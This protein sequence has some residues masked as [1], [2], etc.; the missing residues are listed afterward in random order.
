MRAFLHNAIL[1]V[2]FGVGLTILAPPSVAQESKKEPS[3]SVSGRVTIGDKPVPHAIVLVTR[4]NQGIQRTPPFRATT[5]EDGV[6]RVT[7]VPAGSYT[8][9][10]F[11]PAYVVAPESSF[12]QPGKS[13]SLGEGEEVEDLNFSLARGCVVTG[14]VTDADG[15]PLIEQRVAVMQVDERGQRVPN[16]SFDPFMFATD[17]RGVYRVYGL[18]PGRYK[19]SVGDA[20]DSGMVRIGFGGGIYA[21]TFHP[22]VADESKAPAIEVRA[23]GEAAD[24]DIKM[25]NATR[26]FV[27]TGRIIDADSGKPLPNLQYGHGALMREQTNI[28]GFG[29]TNNRTNENGDFR[30]D[31]LSAGRFAAFVIATEQVDF[32]SEPTVFE[33]TDSDVRGL[34]IRVRHGSSIVGMAVIDGSN[35]SEVVSKLS[36]LELRAFLRSEQ[37]SPPNLAPIRISPD[38]SFRI[39]GLQPGK[40]RIVL[41]GYPPQKGFTLLRVEREGVEQRDGIDIGAG[42]SVAGV[43]VVIGYGTG[44]I[45]GQLKFQG[46][47]PTPEMRYRV[48]AKRLETSESLTTSTMVDTR[49][50]FSFEG[51]VPGDYEIALTTIALRP[52]S[53]GGPPP[54]PGR[55]SQGPL[56]KQNVTVTNGAEADVTLVVELG[57]Q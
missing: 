26:T 27:A 22:N 7:G 3:S 15:R 55:A 57:R 47:Q 42:E 20:P 37:L 41:G 25:A 43:R 6:Y 14:R 34:E 56:A 29:F 54:P 23:G 28:G 11:T 19:I 45:R 32:Y 48:L 50:R 8:V 9:L 2:C 16:S 36:K 1:S 53:P 12:A 5:D 35:D 10:P 30:I 18:A 51:L 38:G 33:V 31:G 52:S 44:V 46:G 49:G 39:T 21:R 17:D 13:V 40:V 4:S 24:V